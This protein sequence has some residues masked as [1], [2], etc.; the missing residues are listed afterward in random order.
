M[1]LHFDIFTRNIYILLFTEYNIENGGEKNHEN[2]QRCINPTRIQRNE[3]C[4]GDI[5]SKNTC[6]PA[7]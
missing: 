2:R 5:R 1:F 7:S 4:D 6:T 3:N